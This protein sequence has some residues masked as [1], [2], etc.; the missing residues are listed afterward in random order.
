MT[1]A[2]PSPRR[3]S[4]RATLFLGLAA[5][6]GFAALALGWQARLDWRALRG[7]EA[8]RE[9][10]E[11]A[12]RFAAG[13]FEVL[14]ER[15]ATNNALQAEAPADAAVLA[16]I[17][18]RRAAVAANFAPGRAALAALD[19]PGREALLR[20]LDAALARA[21]AMRR[22]AD[23]A[24][25]QPRAARDAALRR[26]F[27]PVITASVNASLGVWFA[28][29]HAA[30]AVDPVLARLAMVKEIGWR[31]RD[32]AGFER[33]N[34][35]SAIAAGQPVAADRVA[36][37]AGIRA[38]VDMLW[39][40]FGNLAPPADP[41]T[42]PA[43]RAAAAEARREYFQGFRG[44]ADSMVAAGA[45]APGGRYP[46]AA[47]PFVE[48]T[49]A[50]LG[51]L[52]GVMHAA[53]RAS[54]AR[55]A[56]MVAQRQAE[57]RLASLLVALSLGIAA[58]MG[59]LV[60]RRV[61]RPLAALEGATVRLAEGELTVAV[62]PPAADEVGRLAEAIAVLRDGLVERG[63]LRDA[64]EAARM[65]AAADR[66]ATLNA[67]ANRVETEAR[68]AMGQIRDRMGELGGEAQGVADAAV[69]IAGSAE[70][71]SSAAQAAL[72]STETVA[73][74]TEEL[75]A[76][77]R[78]IAARVNDNAA[79]TRQAV[80]STLASQETI[81]GLA[82][83]VERIG[84]VARLIA[85]IAG[86]TNLLALN[87][88]IEAARAGEAGKGFAVVASEVKQLAA[89]TARAT[90]EI[91]GQIAEVS[92]ATG[93]AV[94]AVRG[95]GEAV[96]AIDRTSAAIAA[97]VEQQGAATAEIARTVAR[98]A[99]A[100]REV[101]SRI[102]EVSQE[103]GRTGGRAGAMLGSISEVGGALDEL[104]HR[105]VQGVRGSTPEV[106]RRQHPRS[107][108]QGSASLELAGQPAQTVRLV[109]LSL[110]GARL[111][112]APALARG[113]AATLRLPGLAAPLRVAVVDSVAGQLG[114]RFE[115][116]DPA[117][118]AALARLLDPGDQG[119]NG[120][121]AAQGRQAA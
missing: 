54:E 42:H 32:T 73:A 52:L 36:A 84:Q 30:A 94:G 24:I 1:L 41:A 37:N 51:T 69:L 106:D 120:G 17:A 14:M 49:T 40:Q 90:E 26:D 28:A 91:G 92:A 80:A 104:R 9:A 113:T 117:A 101:A 79:T 15:L 89:Q 96:E 88:T 109:D 82:Q 93:Q 53:G 20:D 33:S 45:A 71:V 70:A 8:A 64:Q 59:W 16:E 75:S 29:S 19:F 118:E 72:E 50:Q 44:Q 25:A 103:M 81:G 31:L 119:W 18:R 3:L 116:L 87:A 65:A 35:A 105:L 78:E 114:L 38:Q 60:V 107:P 68:E 6:A 12:N 77:I 5:T 13:L 7:A 98:T 34:I 85:D 95:I 61:T 67:M 108:V 48:T 22:Q 74:A 63:R 83:A 100:S 76:S 115:A 121:A 102:G 56:A 43:L 86:R 57:L 112:G 99:E 62:P 4:I 58:A 11:G 27:V 110:G 21:D 111:G 55:G 39:S 46:S 10:D 47:G 23:A 2:L 97:A 66:H